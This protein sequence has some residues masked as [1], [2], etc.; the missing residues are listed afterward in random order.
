[1]TRARQAAAVPP[2]LQQTLA[3]LLFLMLW[4]YVSGRF[5]NDYFIS[6]P[7]AIAARIGLWLQDGTIA[8]HVTATVIITVS[9]FLLAALVAIPLAVVV[10]GSQIADEVLSPYI[11]AAYS[12]PK[13]VLGP[14]LVL[15]LGIG[16][17]PA[18]ALSSITAFFL[19]FYNVYVGLKQIPPIYG[20]TAKLLGAS[21]FQTA[22][23]FRLP[24]ASAFIANGLSQGLIYAFHGAM[25][26]E[27]TASNV[28][29]GYIILF[30]GAR[31]DSAGVMTGLLLIG[32][33]AFALVR[34][35]ELVV[36]RFGDVNG[37]RIAG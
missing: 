19:I 28:G 4:E 30:N 27:M 15:W 1:M 29:V 6:S 25:V 26:G 35:M 36:S 9:G 21:A 22:I 37:G 16:S 14:A 8:R 12:M 18:I 7:S 32:F 3:L 34:G 20:I 33:I 11:Y 31:L 5:I 2:W 24:A 17:A 10:T 13:I 23:K